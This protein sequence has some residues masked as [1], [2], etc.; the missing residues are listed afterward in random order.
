MTSINCC[1]QIV[2]KLYLHCVVQLERGERKTYRATWNH[3]GSDVTGL[4]ARSEK[5]V[6]TCEKVDNVTCNY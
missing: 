3:P 4:V 6:N 2:I 1:I 5:V